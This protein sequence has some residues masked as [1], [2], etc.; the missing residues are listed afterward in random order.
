MANCGRC[1]TLVAASAC[2]TREAIDLLPT[3]DIVRLRGELC[4]AD[5]ECGTS[6]TANNCG[7]TSDVYRL[8]TSD[9]PLPPA[10][11]PAPP[12]SPPAPPAIPLPPTPPLRALA[13]CEAPCAAGSGCGTC[14]DAVVPKFCPP[15]SEIALLPKCEAGGVVPGGLCEADGVVGPP[16]C[17][18]AADGRTEGGP[19]P[20]AGEC[21][22]DP[23][24]NTCHGLEGLEAEDLCIPARAREDACSAVFSRDVR[25]FT[26]QD[27]G[28]STSAELARR[29]SRAAPRRGKAPPSRSGCCSVGP[30]SQRSPWSSPPTRT[31]AAAA[32]RAG[33]PW[34]AAQR[35]KFRE[36]Q[37]R[38]PA[39][40]ISWRSARFDLGRRGEAAGSK[41]PYPRGGSPVV[42]PSECVICVAN[43]RYMSIDIPHLT[44]S[45]AIHACTYIHYR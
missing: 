17:P 38:R 13:A 10:P 2:P 28:T 6:R 22:T 40:S 16:A 39:P 4:E 30:P 9:E 1:L 12:A 33:V 36:G 3:C 19:M 31:A 14:L 32:R 35:A 8:C 34:R 27:G 11:P 43:T 23:T 18:P 25:A 7:E 42:S 26:T 5:G 24:L 45:P 44:A 21:G 37:A 20:A 29:R 41:T 15:E